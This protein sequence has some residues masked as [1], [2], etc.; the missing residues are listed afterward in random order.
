MTSQ[1]TRMHPQPV[2]FRAVLVKLYFFTNIQIL[3][4]LKWNTTFGAHKT[5]NRKS[6]N[7]PFPKNDELTSNNLSLWLE[8]HNTSKFI[9]EQTGSPDETSIDIA[10]CHQPINTFGCDTSPIL[11]PSVFGNFIIVH[12]GQ[13]GAD[14]FVNLIGLI[15]FAHQSSSDGPHGFV[16]NDYIGHVLL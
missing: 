10:L 12:F 11:N 5:E 3:E 7:Q 2:N 6:H 1:D 14:E 13:D 4:V 16:G 9:R 8:V 15:R